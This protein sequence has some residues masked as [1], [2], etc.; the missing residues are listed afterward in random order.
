[1]A[2]AARVAVKPPKPAAKKPPKHP[3][4]EATHANTK[5]ARHALGSHR[6][7]DDAHSSTR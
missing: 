3:R 2:R 1:M 4:W 7:D 6:K 5:V